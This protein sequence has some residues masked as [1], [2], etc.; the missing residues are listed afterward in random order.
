M[1]FLSHASLNAPILPSLHSDAPPNSPATI[2]GVTDPLADFIIPPADGKVLRPGDAGYNDLLPFNL[3]TTV[4]PQVIAQ[5]RTAH[6]VSLAVQWAR[7][8]QFALCGHGGG[9]SYEGFSS[10]SGLM[11]DVRKM[12][13]VV[14][15]AV[16]QT[17]RIGA[18]CL[19]GDVTETLFAQKFA[20]PAGTCKPVG[21]AGLTQGGGHGLSSR[22]FGL[23]CDSLISVHLVD[24]NGNELTASASENPSLFWALRGGGG[25]NFGIVTEFTFKIHPVDRVIEF[26]IVWPDDSFR[27]SILRTWQSVAQSA[28]DELS[29]VLHVNGGQGRISHIA[30]TGMFLPRTAS[31]T[32]SVNDLRT[33]L[34]PLLAIGNP[35]FKPS[36]MSYIEAARIFAGDGDPN[37]VYF[38]AKSDYSLDAW[39]DGAIGTFISALRSSPS[40]IATIFEAYGGAINQLGE[41]DTAFPH[42]GG[43]R[44]CL[45]YY[46]QWASSSST[47]QNVAAIRALYAAM[48]PHLPGYSYVNYID[49]DLHDY[50]PA[51]YKANLPRLQTVK[52]QYD[53]DNLF[54]FAQSIPL[55]A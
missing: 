38:K 24:A 35:R 37:R 27:T 2:A 13:A 39:S 30:C 49:L 43:T 54:H 34:G 5:C 40:P 1:P 22:K 7:R 18:G 26:S 55:P 41:A 32:P 46:L 31:Q 52:Q 21:I 20:L 50:A 12:S 19:L 47:N 42:R 17:A 28:P 6:G 44:F 51:Y 9:H 14:I 48:R 25:G 53:P 10:C 36:E 8:H 45:Q 3:R 16:N 11:I 15:D 23:T 29:F 33:V 4:R